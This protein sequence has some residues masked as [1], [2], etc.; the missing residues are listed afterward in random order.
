MLPAAESRAPFWQACGTFLL[1]ALLW[2]SLGIYLVSESESYGK[3]VGVLLFFTLPASFIVVMA[4]WFN[5]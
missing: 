1:V 5:P 2:S 3:A 4:P